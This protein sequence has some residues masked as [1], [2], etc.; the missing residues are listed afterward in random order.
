M[1]D[2]IEDQIRR[3]IEDGQ[4]ENLPGK[5]KPL[6]L[7]DNPFEDPEWRM[8]HR[9]LKEA[10]FSLPWIESRREIDA[11]IES[12]RA[13]LQQAWARRQ[14]SLSSDKGWAAVQADWSGARELF[15]TRINAINKLILTHNLQAPL[16]QFQMM[17]LDVERE[18]ARIAG[19]LA[20]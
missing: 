16:D 5:G 1:V 13:A 12:A 4:F 3:A 14:F 19:G 8:A 15:A 7:D 10:G 11:E 20:E 17:A 2:K 18:I 9:M 6:N